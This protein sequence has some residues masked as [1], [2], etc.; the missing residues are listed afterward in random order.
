MK[1]AQTT[2]D[3]VQT[4]RLASFGPLVCVLLIIRVL[5]IPIN[6]TQVLSTIRRRGEGVVGYDDEAG[7][8]NTRHGPNDASRVVWVFGT[9]SLN[10]S[11]FIHSN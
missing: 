7:S 2:P 10:S 11:C 6:Y 1:Q 8:D 3:M 5:Y 4:T 9:C